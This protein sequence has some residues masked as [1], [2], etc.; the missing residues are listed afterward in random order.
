MHSKSALVKIIYRIILVTSKMLN[1]SLH[2]VKIR[3]LQISFQDS[4]VTSELRNIK[5]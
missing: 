3:G 1:H 2:S 5:L 4:V